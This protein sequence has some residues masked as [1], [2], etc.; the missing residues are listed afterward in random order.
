MA[1]DPEHDEETRQ[2][3][4]DPSHDLDMVPLYFSQTIEAAS[5]AEVL[6]GILESN[7][8]PTIMTNSAPGF[9]NL[10][11][12]ITVPRDRADEALRL[13]AEAQE[14][15]PQGAAEAEAASEEK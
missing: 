5:E 3:A 12:L 9:P 15:G 8:I 14:A 2:D 4:V 1:Q 10:G 13:I 11:Y 6:R 7:G